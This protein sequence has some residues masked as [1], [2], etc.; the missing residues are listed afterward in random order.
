MLTL[1]PIEFNSTREAQCTLTAFR[2]RYRVALR[3]ACVTGP[4]YHGK[5]AIHV[6]FGGTGFSPAEMAGA[7]QSI[8]V[9]K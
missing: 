5:Y 2:K 7:M 3:G 4:N 8:E 9:N 6:Q 1:V